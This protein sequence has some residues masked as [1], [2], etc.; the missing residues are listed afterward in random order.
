MREGLVASLVLGLAVGTLAVEPVARG[1][2]QELGSVLG[3]T[4]ADAGVGGGLPISART[5]VLT[6]LVPVL[7]GVAA[8]LLAWPTAWCLRSL[9]PGRGRWAL[10]LL[11]VPMVLPTYLAFAGWGLARGPGTLVALWMSRVPALSALLGQVLACVS[12]ALWS[13]PIATFVLLGPVG[14]VPRG[15][16]E[17]LRLLGAGTVRG[18]WVLAR[19]VQPAIVAAVALVALL[20][21]GSAVPLHLAQ[22]DTLA[23]TLWAELALR[24]DGHGAWARAWPLLVVAVVAAVVLARSIGGGPL[25]DVPGEEPVPARWRLGVPGVLAWTLGVAVPMACFALAVHSWPAAVRVWGESLGPLWESVL[26]GVCVGVGL[27]V[28]ALSAWR[29]ASAGG[30]AGVVARVALGCLAVMAV[31]PGVFTGVLVGASTSAQV[32]EV[33]LPGSVL[34]IVLGHLAR[35]GVLGVGAGMLLSAGE[36]MALRDLRHQLAGGSVRGW[37]RLSVRPWA[38][39]LVGLACAGG[40]LSMHEIEATV[41]LRPP[42]TRP[43]AQ[44]M[45]DN[46]HMNSLQELASTGVMVLLGTVV[47]AVLAGVLLAPRGVPRS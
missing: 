14:R 8:T 38:G 29:C 45:L 43:I 4:A 10:A 24:P 15:E 44:I 31:V 40:A 37:L 11:I 23:I 42:G 27:V 20:M 19:R 34:P 7:I 28:L 18:Q 9:G 35:F 1:V 5:M 32:A 47:L 3:G 13:W 21:L 30:W 17:A 22:I 16:V 2:A 6:V 39:V 46:L 26:T 33:V 12:L 36:P 41:Q 25:A